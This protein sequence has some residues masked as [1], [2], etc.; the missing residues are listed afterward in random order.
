MFDGR[1]G[2]MWIG[3]GRWDQRIVIQMGLRFLRS[4][5]V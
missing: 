2:G 3:K 4:L 1:N 5:V